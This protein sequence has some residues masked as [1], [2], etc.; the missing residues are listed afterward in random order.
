MAD[1]RHYQ[2]QAEPTLDESQRPEATFPDKYE[3]HYPRQARPISRRRE[4]V[5]AFVEIS[6]PA[7]IDFMSALEPQPLQRTRAF[8]HFQQSF[9]AQVDTA[10]FGETVFPDKYAPSYPLRTRHPKARRQSSIAFLDFAVP[11]VPTDVG[12]GWVTQQPV[13]RRAKP[14]RQSFITELPTVVFVET[15]FPDKYWQPPAYSTARKK[16]RKQGWIAAPEFI[17]TAVLIYDAT[18]PMRQLLNPANFSPTATFVFEGILRTNGGTTARVRLFNIT[19][20]SAV[21]EVGT[22]L[23]TF[24]RIRVAITLPTGDNEY[25]AEPARMSDEPSTCEVHYAQIIVDSQ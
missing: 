7:P 19:T 8:Q 4:S 12:M 3:G 1:D 22:T 9:V 13:P 18:S 15:V 21:A 5:I 2:V 24:Q 14:R 20:S 16:P 23:G 25:R 10:V 17:P 6:V 11:P